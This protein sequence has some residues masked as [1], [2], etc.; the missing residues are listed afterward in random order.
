MNPGANKLYVSG[1]LYADV[2]SGGSKPFIIEDPRYG[3]P[4]KRLTHVAIEGPEAAVFYRGESRLENGE[5]SVKLPDYFE[6]LTRKEGRT[7]VLTNVDGFDNIAVK[8]QGEVQVKDGKFMVYSDNKDSTQHFS[9][10]VKAVRADI[11]PI[12]PE[13]TIKDGVER[14]GDGKT[15]NLGSKLSTVPTSQAPVPKI[16]TPLQK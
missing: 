2:V 5:T 4:N 11:N 10:E 12:V 16:E 9:W 13:T 15:V 1:T 14:G 3:D 8:S 7:V 6:A